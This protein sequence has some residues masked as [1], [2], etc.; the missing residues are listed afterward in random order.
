MGAENVVNI[1][2]RLQ[3]SQVTV[4][5]ISSVTRAL[6]GSAGAATAATTATTQLTS[7]ATQSA[8]AQQQMGSNLQQLAQRALVYV[9]AVQLAQ[10]AHRALM[11]QD[12]YTGLVARLTQLEGSAQ[13]G[14]AALQQVAAIADRQGAALEAVGS[15][16]TRVGS[17]VRRLGGDS[18]ATAR[19]VETV[20]AALRLQNATT[21]ETSSVMLQFGQAMA[22]GKVNG[23]EFSSLMENA[24][25]LMDAVAAAL[26]KTQGELYSMAEA[27][28][29]TSAVFGQG[30]LASFDRITAAAAQM[31]QTVG[32]AA[33]RMGNA[34]TMA[35]GQSKVAAG[36][37]QTAI[38]GLSVVAQNATAVFE[39]ASAGAL[40]LAAVLGGRLVSSLA[41]AAAATAAN[42]AALLEEL[43]AKVQAAQADMQ[44][45]SIAMN[46][47]RSQ[48][49]ATEA[50]AAAQVQLTRTT[51]ATAAAQAELAA[52]QSLTRGALMGVLGV[53]GGP[54]GLIASLALA[55]A[56]WW[57]Y[58][59][60]S[61]GGDETDA[62]LARLEAQ[63]AALRLTTKAGQDAAKA[64]A[65]AAA[66]PE[67]GFD[68]NTGAYVF[69]DSKAQ[70]LEAKWQRIGALQAEVA[71]GSPAMV[72]PQLTDPARSLAS[73]QQEYGGRAQVQ[74][75]YEDK[76]RA[77]NAGAEADRARAASAAG[78][79]EAQRTAALARVE[80]ER[81]QMLAEAAAK[82][83]AD[84][85]SAGQAASQLASAQAALTLQQQRNASDARLRAMD[86][87][88]V[89]LATRRDADLV[90]LADY[91]D[92]K[93]AIEA[94]M[95]AERLAMNA[96]EQAEVSKQRPVGA[97]AAAQKQTELTKLEGEAAKLR[98]D[99]AAA[100]GKNLQDYYDQSAKGY[101]KAAE[102]LRQAGVRAQQQ[103]LA[104]DDANARDAIALITDPVARAV[105]A[106]VLEIAQA[107]QQAEAE[108]DALQQKIAQFR[109]SRYDLIDPDAI[110]QLQDKITQRKSQLETRETLIGKG[111]DE[112]LKPQWQ[113]TLEGWK[114]TTRVMRD[115]WDGAITDMVDGAADAFGK[116]VSGQQVNL[117]G[118]V[119]GLAYDLG[120]AQ[121]K[122]LVG[123]LTGGQSGSGGLV[124]VLR[125]LSGRSP[126]LTT[127]GYSGTEGDKNFMGP[128][129]D[130]ATAIDTAASSSADALTGAAASFTNPVAGLMGAGQSLVQSALGWLLPQSAQ[131]TAAVSLGTAATELIG[132]AAM[133]GASGGGG[134]G[135][136]DLLDLAA[137]YF[138][139][140]KGGTYGSVHAFA[141]GGAFSRGG[142]VLT[143]PTA[144][145]FLEGA[146]IRYGLAG[147]AG[148]EAAVPLKSGQ[149]GMRGI[150]VHGARG[151]QVLPLSRGPDG[152][153]GVA[154]AAL[155]SLTSPGRSSLATAARTDGMAAFAMGGVFGPS[156]SLARGVAVQ[157]QSV[158]SGMGRA[159]DD[160]GSGRPSLSISMPATMYFDA[161]SDQAQLA[162][163]VGQAMSAQERRLWRQMR[164][165]GL[166]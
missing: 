35:A 21:S 149:G 62:L 139:A 125:G 143:G 76:V 147:E 133:L 73:L 66:A 61:E 9:G 71:A 57:A 56:G 48:V 18:A 44:R 102:D 154:A 145:R 107:R 38:A 93:A 55:A 138:F 165:R 85:K 162:Q 81:T 47:A 50:A 32:Q 6:Q 95:L 118:L 41:A 17:S 39:L 136:G 131:T 110:P 72:A 22:K 15:V 142:E 34:F 65:L 117:K 88:L 52:A 124:D 8:A 45:A 10:Q 14:A 111:L 67:V 53:F 79:T 158:R 161:R 106:S 29:L 19:I 3:G 25:K 91:A 16:Y 105:A 4:Q 7:A 150:T 103:I 86:A 166:V 156:D 112:Q 123:N 128:L 126:T 70:A 129:Q 113:R 42:R 13:G 40:G 121:F 115:A 28:K 148:P 160:K 11:A 1:T 49:L 27:G 134:G 99:A 89:A 51:L 96:N 163:L 127:K 23:D 97:A 157:G 164:E 69:D 146:Q 100:A 31:P 90:D 151:R 155:Q 94:R 24:P 26:G 116:F 101:E 92:Q 140:A 82:R 84:L 122:G 152:V 2:L 12:A 114:D 80:A 120:K 30:V 130:S 37:S 159:D 83:D 54:A 64:K 119:Q 108:I 63:A 46:A 5:G 104:A 33:Q 144:F 58:R 77:I 74:Q 109:A 60:A 20:A 43:A 135:S 75:E 98:D 137:Q 36:V 59:A 141:A 78:T 132:A 68:P 153:L 87:E